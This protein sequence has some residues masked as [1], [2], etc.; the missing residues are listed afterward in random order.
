MKKFSYSKHLRLWLATLAGCFILA[1]HAQPGA[2]VRPGDILDLT[3]TGN[4]PLDAMLRLHADDVEG[5]I[6]SGTGCIVSG[7]DVR[8]SPEVDMDARAGGMD[9]TAKVIQAGR[10]L[11]GA[12]REE[13]LAKILS[14][15]VAKAHGDFFRSMTDDQLRE[16]VSRATGM[17]AARLEVSP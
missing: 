1:A 16:L 9:M 10:R 4:G 8:T 12:S 3:F 11:E 17:L 2:E 14:N 15:P 5:A 6:A 7:M 13:I